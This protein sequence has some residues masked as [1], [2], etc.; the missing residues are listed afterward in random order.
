MSAHPPPAAQSAGT[1]APGDARP[2]ARSPLRRALAAS[3]ILLALLIAALPL[4]RQIFFKGP[5]QAVDPDLPEGVIDLHCHVA[6]IGAGGSGCFVSPAMRANI[7]FRVFLDAFGVTQKELTERGDALVAERLSRRLAESRFVRA[8]VILAMDGVIDDYGRLD[9][10]RTEVFV[11]DEFVA[12]LARRHTNLLYGASI[13]PRRLDAIQRLDQ[14][15]RDGA[16][17]VKWLPSIMEIDPSDPAFIPFYQRLRELGIPLLTHTGDEKS[18]TTARAELADPRRL[19]LPLEHGVTVIAAHVAA[20]IET[21][22][23]PDMDRLFQLMSE[24]PNLHADISALTQVNRV[25]VLGKVLSAPECAGRLVYGSDFP[26][27]NTAL[28]SPWHFL[29]NLT[30]AQR[31]E[32]SAVE[33]PWDRDIRLKHA[34]GVPADVFRPGASLIRLEPRA[35]TNG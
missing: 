11:P 14:A 15:A 33:N 16:V 32:I 29:L 4:A 23:V 20:G 1:P 7:R 18:F 21:G 25:G 3:A 27:I 24:F 9:T 34:L 22:G 12:E 2:R 31:E 28:V 8:A 30:E 5:Y 19:R 13:N 17:L 26:L 6:G 10:N 35:K